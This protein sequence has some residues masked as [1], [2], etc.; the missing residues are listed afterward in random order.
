MRVA[1]KAG[2]LVFSNCS[3]RTAVSQASS[4]LYLLMD[5][6]NSEFLCVIFLMHFMGWY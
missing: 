3:A 2:S 5:V 1:L 4:F 6:N